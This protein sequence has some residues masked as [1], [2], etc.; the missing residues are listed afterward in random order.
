MPVGAW[1]IIDE[2]TCFNFVGDIL[3]GVEFLNSKGLVHGDIKG[4]SFVGNHLRL[5]MIISLKIIFSLLV[6]IYVVTRFLR[7]NESHAWSLNP[8]DNSFQKFQ[9]ILSWL[10]KLTYYIQTILKLNWFEQFGDQE[11]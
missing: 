3:K 7:G 4:S 11:I 2:G 5:E 9:T 6:A 8:S 10:R 1:P